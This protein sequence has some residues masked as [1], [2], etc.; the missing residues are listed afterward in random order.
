MKKDHINEIYKKHFIVQKE[1][2]NA[3]LRFFDIS[4][5]LVRL[6]LLIIEFNE[7]NRSSS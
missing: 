2:L 4:R 1:I 6:K 5:K 3:S 7:F